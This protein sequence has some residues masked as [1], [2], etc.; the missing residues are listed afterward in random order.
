MSPCLGFTGQSL[1]FPSRLRRDLLRCLSRPI[2][3]LAGP[4]EGL[5]GG[6][7]GA[8][9][10]LLGLLRAL[11]GLLRPV[12]DLRFGAFH[13]LP[14]GCL[15]GKALAFHTVLGSGACSAYALCLLALHLGDRRVGFLL[16]LLDSCPRAILGVLAGTLERVQW[17]NAMDLGGLARGSRD[18]PGRR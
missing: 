18:L 2:G 5:V 15:L 1:G 9:R 14:C 13:D 16:G 11:L 8:S 12:R 3:E 10:L 17:V 7:D 4:H 6:L